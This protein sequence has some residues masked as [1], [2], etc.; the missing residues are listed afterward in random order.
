MCSFA[1]ISSLSAAIRKPKFGGQYIQGSQIFF[2]SIS[3]VGQALDLDSVILQH[4]YFLIGYPFG[5]SKGCNGGFS[6]Y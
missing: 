2:F 5:V 1:F 6:G 4:L 3:L